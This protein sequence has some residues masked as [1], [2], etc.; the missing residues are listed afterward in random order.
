MPKLNLKYR[1]PTLEEVFHGQGV[2]HVVKTSSLHG[3]Y[4]WKI[5]T[6]RAG[7]WTLHYEKY[8]QRK[9]WLDLGDLGQRES[10]RLGMWG[11]ESLEGAT[12][13]IEKAL[14]KLGYL[15]HN[16]ELEVRGVYT[17]EVK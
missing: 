5:R 8:N 3:H 17:K 11:F 10:F 16:E 12:L 7:L 13:R 4:Q 1:N 9:V 6:G 2:D 15:A 14:K